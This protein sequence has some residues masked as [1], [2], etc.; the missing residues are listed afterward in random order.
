MSGDPTDLIRAVD[1]V[2]VQVWDNCLNACCSGEECRLRTE[3]CRECGD[4]WPCE[5]RRLR[6]ALVAEK[7][8]HAVALDTAE[9]LRQDAAMSRAAIERVRMLADLAE[10]DTAGG[11][12]EGIG[13]D[14]AAGIRRA[15]EDRS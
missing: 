7:F 14:V 9:V 15:V 12:F 5:V 1:E 2:H 8:D 11:V 4:P 6:D 13:R 10:R 3:V